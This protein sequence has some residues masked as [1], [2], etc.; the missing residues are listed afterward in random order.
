LTY[1]TIDCINKNI[2]ALKK[3]I[4]T[5]HGVTAE[6]HRITEINADYARRTL[7]VKLDLYLNKVARDLG[8]KSL[9]YA[10][11]HFNGDQFPE[12]VADMEPRAVLYGLLKQQHGFG[13]AEDV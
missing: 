6:Y 5:D 8:S 10:L 9:Q 3:E 1:A 2:M 11:F 13:D 12:D 7:S 4:V